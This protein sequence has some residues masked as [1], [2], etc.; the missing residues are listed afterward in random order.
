MEDFL[1][2]LQENA[3]PAVWS[4]GVALSREATFIRD[5]EPK[6]PEI[7]IRVLVKN[8]PVHPRVSLWP[9]E[10]DAYCDCGD[11]NDP[12]IHIIA[13]ALAFK[14]GTLNASQSQSKSETSE[15]LPLEN[16]LGI[17]YRFIKQE[18]NLELE[19]WVCSQRGTRKLEESL[20]SFIG[21]V[22][23]G[24]I[25][26]P[27]VATT[28]EDFAIDALLTQR[29][30]VVRSVRVLD[31][32]SWG[33]LLSLLDNAAQV[34]LDD[35]PVKT[36]GSVFPFVLELI[37][38]QE[39]A[40]GV[41]YRLRRKVQDSLQE[42]FLQGVV[43]TEGTLR[44]AQDPDLDP[45]QKQWIKGEGSFF[46]ASKQVT[47]VS[48][49]L[50]LLQKKLRIEINTEKLP[51]LVESL[52]RIAL[53]IDHEGVDAIS[54]VADL[55]YGNP[56]I[57]RVR[58]D[59]GGA[60]EM[61]SKSEV[62]IRDI[63]LEKI[64][65]RDLQANLH[66]QPGNRI[67]LHG[68]QAARFLAEN[69][70]NSSLLSGHLTGPEVSGS[71]SAVLKLGQDGSLELEF[72]AGNGPSAPR[73]EGLTVIQAWKAGRSFFPVT[74]N[75][76]TPLP[77]DWLNRFGEQILKLL[78]ARNSQRILPKYLLPQAIE[79][80]TEGLSELP[81]YLEKLRIG[82]QD[83]KT[84][85][86]AI[87]PTD[88]KGELRHYQK[89]GVKWLKFLAQNQ[90]GALLADDMGLGK[91]LQTLCAIRGRS[92]IICPTSV[93][94]AWKEQIKK[95]RPGLQAIVYHGQNRKFPETSDQNLV[96]LTSYGILRADQELLL[97]KDWDTI[98]LDEAH[99]IKN[100]DSQIARAVHELALIQPEK[101]FRIALSG[102]PVENRLD[103]LWSQFQFVNPGLL[104]SRAEF[105]EHFATPIHRGDSQAGEL[106]RKRVRPFLLRRLKR[107]VAPELPPRTEVLLHCEL[108]SAE[109]G[110]Y[111]SLLLASR[112]EV[113]QKLEQDGNVFA[114][115][116]ALLRLRQT[117]CHPALVPGGPEVLEG[118]SS[119]VK[120]LLET[121]ED[122]ISS[123]HRSLI[124]SQWTSFLDLLEPEL[125][126]Q[127]IAFLRLDGST[128]DREKVVQAFQDPG[129]PPVFLLSLKAGG[130][131]LNL[132]AAD[133]VFILDPWWNPAVE[134]QAAD[135]AHRIGQT[136]PVLIHRLVAK[137]T[138]EDK[139]LE[140]QQE[141][142]RL[143][144]AVLNATENA[145]SPRQA[146]SLTK[147]DIL[148]LLTS[149]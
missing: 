77:H 57:S 145:G 50:P 40:P 76:W 69:P 134:D 52:P 78:E 121:L 102:T 36:S 13:A 24:R 18:R 75:S 58:I 70:Q 73:I 85:P 67:H 93:L 14:N 139:I 120:L 19:R 125:T 126:A 83:I 127:G 47:L 133:H 148:H 128:I 11:K 129:G 122:S 46:P 32:S 116:E 43:L 118:T 8:R 94:S 112:T 28:R 92:L 34:L 63:A 107:E 5:S 105:Q 1:K 62:P 130:V 71:L 35:K 9:N 90:L 104:G 82:L 31:R 96:L 144:G 21:G 53:T 79:L 39:S 99:W 115:L 45:Q 97:N 114:A 109:R 87:L 15:T 26:H 142:R 91:T 55:V 66:L 23:S 22:Q 3:L 119:K 44:P 51:K 89:E 111:D 110:F 2:T 146:E 20:V 49:I 84:I 86:E 64:L 10:A 147:E 141:K 33:K 117:C 7:I 56:P 65:L 113:L 143:S 108:S 101:R 38:E 12:C 27:P 29:S 37:E 25:A 81:D 61:I 138:V 123:E 72:T 103:D 136:N 124:F 98:V 4:R 106:L 41:G 68:D 135:R 17:S 95:F 137:N 140:I 100:P 131:G 60:L 16:F 132:T 80:Q 88:L 48:E 59:R 149:P 54:V 42:V 30:A 74:Q 6:N